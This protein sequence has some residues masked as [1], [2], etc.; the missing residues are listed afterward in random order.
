MERVFQEANVA[1]EKSPAPF[2]CAS[3]QQSGV[4]SARWDCSGGQVLVH[5]ASGRHHD[6]AAGDGDA[7]A[8]QASG[9]HAA[10]QMQ[11]RRG[12]GSTGAARGGA[13]G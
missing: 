11:R 4:A 3:S 7:G 5:V 8:G 2:L 10:S 1:G 9:H 13:G 6:A 12:T